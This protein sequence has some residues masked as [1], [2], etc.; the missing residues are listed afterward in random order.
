MVATFKMELPRKSFRGY[1]HD[2]GAGVQFVFFPLSLFQLRIL[3]LHTPLYVFTEVVALCNVLL[4]LP[5]TY[6]Y[7]TKTT[8]QADFFGIIQKTNIIL[9]NTW[10]M[11]VSF[12]FI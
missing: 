11:V 2:L 5:I 6:L 10:V 7:F 12:M 3:L 9:M 4:L 8:H 1:L